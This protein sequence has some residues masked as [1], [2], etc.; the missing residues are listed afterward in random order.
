MR[1]KRLTGLLTGVSINIMAVLYRVLSLYTLQIRK[2]QYNS[3]PYIALLV[4]WCIVFGVLI[5]LWEQCNTGLSAVV[6]LILALV[7]VLLFWESREQYI[8]AYHLIIV[9]ACL[10]KM[11]E[12]G[13]KLSENNRR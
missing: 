10:K 11:I 1:K 7:I 2:A 6:N 4:I 9:G 8:S 12:R 13:R 5:S 3:I